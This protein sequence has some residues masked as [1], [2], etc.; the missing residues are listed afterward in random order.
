MSVAKLK[1]AL[2]LVSVSADAGKNADDIAHNARASVLSPR[3][4][5][6]CTTKCA[7]L[8]ASCDDRFG[9]RRDA[10]DRVFRRGAPLS[11]V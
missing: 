10:E 5:T 4:M 6:G 3:R 11:S 9:H 8:L 2:H 1:S 7:A